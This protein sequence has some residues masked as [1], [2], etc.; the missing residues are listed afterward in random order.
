MRKSLR[1]VERPCQVK[2]DEIELAP[3]R[4]PAS[5]F[6]RSGL[7]RLSDL[8]SSQC[9]QL[10]QH[11]EQYQTRY[12]AESKRF[13]STA[14]AWPK[15]PLHFWSR[16]WEYPYVFHHL[17]AF[18]QKQARKPVVADVG[19]G[20]TF[21][22]FAVADI[23]YD[24]ICCDID[25]VAAGDLPRAIE[26]IP[27]ENQISFRLISGDTLPFADEELDAIYC[28]SVLEHIPN[29]ENT[30]AEMFR[31][32]KYMGVL[33][34]TIDISIKGPREITPENRAKLSRALDSRF[35][36]MPRSEVPLP[37]ALLSQPV[38]QLA[39][40][41]MVLVKNPS[42]PRQDLGALASYSQL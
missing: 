39:V 3:M 12:T 19:S 33:I 15:D 35:Q 13:L 10:F 32:L 42:K 22:P 34:L 20:V 40:E 14:Y 26:T 8:D 21:F 18:R 7:A 16:A 2:Q 37:E 11:L 25:P 1:T 28:I 24:V 4:Q 30:V 29:F 9:K 5:V 27:H 41:G 17:T 31:C 23:G 38:E 36:R 6:E